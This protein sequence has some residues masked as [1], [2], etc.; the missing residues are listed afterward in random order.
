MNETVIEAAANR[1]GIIVSRFNGHISEEMLQGA[2]EAFAAHEVERDLIDIQYVPGAFELPVVA[3][4]MA[5][6][7]RYR[8]IIALGAVIRGDTAHFEYVSSACAHGLSQ[9]GVEYLL[10]VIFGVLTTDTVEQAL[11]RA[12]RQ[13]GNKGYEMAMAAMETAQALEQL[14][15][16]E[17]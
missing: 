2:L 10:P 6:C 12:E 16:N 1:Y 9:V 3:G 17:P 4:A 13:Q 15:G 7:G 5:E 11:E 8:A 14:A